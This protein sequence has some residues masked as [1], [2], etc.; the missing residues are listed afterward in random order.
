LDEGEV[1]MPE[2]WSGF[3]EEYYKSDLLQGICLLVFL[4]IWA[5]D[6]FFFGFTTFLSESIPFYVRLGYASLVCVVSFWFMK[7]SHRQVFE[8]V[9]ETPVIID[10][11]VFALVRHPMYLGVLLF[12][13]ALVISTLSLASLALWMGVLLFYDKLAT[14]EEEDLVRVFGEDYLEY[15]R[16]VPKWLPEFKAN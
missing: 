3:G 14:Y 5:S 10:T 11:E 16:R 6:S 13:M 12:Y 2:V 8:E 4:I 15:R 9:Y 7:V 1:R